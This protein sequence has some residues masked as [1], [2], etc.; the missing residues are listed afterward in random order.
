[1][2]YSVWLVDVH[3]LWHGRMS[4]SSSNASLY[5]IV[6]EIAERS[7]ARIPDSMHVYFLGLPWTIVELFDVDMH[8]NSWEL[9]ADYWSLDVKCCS[10][11]H[12]KRCFFVDR[13]LTTTK[14]KME[15]DVSSQRSVIE[16]ST[17]R[18]SMLEN[19]LAKETVDITVAWMLSCYQ[20]A[21]ALCNNV[22]SVKTK[23]CQPYWTG[24]SNIMDK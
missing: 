19:I 15:T 14:R 17:S 2:L 11:A 20:D 1:M 7:T 12:V 10:F 24:F 8:T 6:I 4:V 3:S 13:D 22:A 5:I 23:K 18:I 9:I 16:E 21:V